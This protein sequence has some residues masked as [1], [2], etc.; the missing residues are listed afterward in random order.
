MKNIRTVVGLA[1]AAAL[2]IAGYL[3]L[4]GF[5]VLGAPTASVKPVPAGHQEVAWIAPATSDDAWA[6]LVEAV[7]YVVRT[8]PELYPDRPVLQASFEQAF[9]DLTA[10]VPEVSLWF[11]GQENNVLWLRWYKLASGVGTPVWVE[12]LV[13]RRRPPL[14]I[15]GGDTSDRAVHMART[16]QDRVGDWKKPTPLFLITTATA[17]R[18]YREAGGVQEGLTDARNPK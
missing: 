5:E 1:L 18:F 2:V 16:L 12:K 9:L 14:A 8:W 13:E 6:R 17:D 11:Q 7:R 10:D 3:T 4:R 15:L